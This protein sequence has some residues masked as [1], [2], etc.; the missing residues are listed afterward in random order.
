MVIHSDPS[1][2]CAARMQ[3]TITVSTSHYMRDFW[4]LWWKEHSLPLIFLLAFFSLALSF[5]LSC[6]IVLHSIVH[7]RKE[8]ISWFIFLV[9]VSSQENICYMQAGFLIISGSPILKLCQA[10]SRPL[11]IFFMISFLFLQTLNCKRKSR[12]EILPYVFLM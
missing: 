8:Y 12:S 7:Y 1:L 9:S 4:L 5:P 10:Q 2:V 11:K 6:F 3:M